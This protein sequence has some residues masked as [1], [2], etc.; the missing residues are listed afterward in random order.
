M[1]FFFDE[2]LFDCSRTSLQENDGG[3]ESSKTVASG[4]VVG[5]TGVSSGLGSGSGSILSAGGH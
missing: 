2:M 5:S 3:T 1:F 4:H